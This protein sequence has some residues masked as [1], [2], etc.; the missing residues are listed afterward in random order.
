M[1]RL[2][3]ASITIICLYSCSSSNGE[4][5]VTLLK[6]VNSSLYQSNQIAKLSTGNTI[7]S[8]RD[9]AKD[10]ST[11]ERATKWLS[12]ATTITTL[13]DSIIQ[14]VQKIKSDLIE[15]AGLDPLKEEK[16]KSAE[17]AVQHIFK[18]HKEGQLLHE[19]LALYKKDLLAIVVD[20]ALQQHMKSIISI[21][22]TD[23]ISKENSFAE[24]YFN[25]TLLGAITMLNKIENDLR[26][27]ENKL[28]ILC[29]EQCS[30]IDRG[31]RSYKV[32]INQKATIIKTGEKMN[33]T[34]GIGAY[35]IETRPSFTIADKEI[36]VNA[37]G[38]AQ[39]DFK[40]P[41]K[42]G[43]NR[44]PVVIK[45]YN[46]ISGKE[47]TVKETVEYTVIAQ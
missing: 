1:L 8:L 45:F 42:P 31:F 17:Q 44:I 3:S 26:N 16:P 43:I 34:V 15:E 40:A 4:S 30:P 37:E 14:Y 2:L 6:E 29:N 11:S 32:I 38:F 39:Y 23:M 36:P 25:T 20:S 22:G 47:V 41:A 27:T 35:S 13:T 9:K 10:P 46:D 19:K 21:T 7:G 12:K 24:T 33:I 18:E 5:E 28:T